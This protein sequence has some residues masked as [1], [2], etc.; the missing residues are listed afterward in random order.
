MNNSSNAGTQNNLNQDNAFN[1]LNAIKEIVHMFNNDIQKDYIDKY[2]PYLKFINNNTV[3]D[4]VDES[5]PQTESYKK[6]KSYFNPIINLKTY[7]DFVNFSNNDSNNFDDLGTNGEYVNINDTNFKEKVNDIS[8]TGIKKTRYKPS[9]NDLYSNINVSNNLCS[10]SGQN[11]SC[12][13]G[14]INYEQLKNALSDGFENVLN[15]LD[16]DKS[17]Q[18]PFGRGKIDLLKYISII[19]SKD[20]S[21]LPKYDSYI[22]KQIGKDMFLRDTIFIN[23]DNL[24]TH[25]NSNDVLSNAL[26]T[27]QRT[28]R[29]NIIALYILG[30]LDKYKYS[31]NDMYDILMKILLL[32]HQGIPG[33]IQI[34]IM[35]YNIEI[36]KEINEFCDTQNCS[37]NKINDLGLIFSLEKDDIF[38]PYNANGLVTNKYIKIIINEN[39]IS[40]YSVFYG[41]FNV[42]SNDY[43]EAFKAGHNLSVLHFDI[44]N[45]TYDFK[46]LITS[47][48]IHNPIMSS[49]YENFKENIK[50]NK[51]KV[52]L[53][54]ALALGALSAIPIMLLLGGNKT[55]KKN[56]NKNKNNRRKNKTHHH[57]KNL[58]K[59][60]NKNKNDRKKH[61]NRNKKTQ[62]QK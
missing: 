41:I 26:V 38:E 4:N 28:D 44:L 54:S 43:T 5:L 17:I 34:L 30:I 42:V 2:T 33:E 13:V 32:L 10:I 9:V 57:R 50:Q 48:N 8:S 53:G 37:I 24:S 60:K 19:C 20:I 6:I 22:K 21:E 3:N 7:D 62:K 25:L 56:K 27:I 36:V 45:N 46:Y 49:K 1:R 18:K 47:L 59:N 29:T 23:N 39:E 40:V 31:I 35:K 58:T 52:G 15:K 51:T 55:K 14:N 12:H 61:K 11:I 16:N